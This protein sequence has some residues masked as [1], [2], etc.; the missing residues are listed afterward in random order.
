MAQ[1]SNVYNALKALALADDRTVN[2]REMQ[3]LHNWLRNQ[4]EIVKE[5]FYS[6]ILTYAEQ[7]DNN[8]AAMVYGASAMGARGLRGP[9]FEQLP[10]LLARMLSLMPNF[11]F[12]ISCL[13]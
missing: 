7:E 12:Q 11:R 1:P 4:T 5:L 2:V 10:P 8:H 6:I 13:I 3:T 9:S